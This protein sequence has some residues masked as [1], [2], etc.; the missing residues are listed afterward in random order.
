MAMTPSQRRN[1]S[2][3]L[4]AS[5]LGNGRIQRQRMALRN[6]GKTAQ[7]SPKPRIG[8]TMKGIRRAFIVEPDRAWSTGALAEWT[9]TLPIYRGKTSQRHWHNHRRA[10]RRACERL[11]VRVGRSQTGSGRGWLWRLADSSSAPQD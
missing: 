8:R 10:I 11:C 9:H 2:K 4:S 3:R 7:K 6:I 5:R 1:L